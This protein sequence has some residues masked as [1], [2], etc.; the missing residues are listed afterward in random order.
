M[1]ADQGK[2]GLIGFVLDLDGHFTV[3]YKAYVVKNTRISTTWAQKSEKQVKKL[4]NKRS[5]IVS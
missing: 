1:Q 4:S 3:S 2:Y 5:E